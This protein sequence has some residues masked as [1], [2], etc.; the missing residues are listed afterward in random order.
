MIGPQ[1]ERE[2]KSA[3]L[4]RSAGY[5]QLTVVS[6]D[7]AFGDCQPQSGAIASATRV[8]V[9]DLGKFIKDPRLV[10]WG[11]AYPAVLNAYFHLTEFGMRADP[12]NDGTPGGGEF[13]GITY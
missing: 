1:G 7:D 11:N 3:A 13:Q 12:N 10:F 9:P 8:R 4:A 2:R 5:T 6:L